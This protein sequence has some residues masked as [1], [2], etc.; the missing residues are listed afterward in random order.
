MASDEQIP[1]DVISMGSD[2]EDEHTPGEKRPLADVEGE[3]G[4]E[5]QPLHISKRPK[6]NRASLSSNASKAS[7]DGEIEES[8]SKSVGS[9]SGQSE[10]QST[11]KS[12]VPSDPPLFTTDTVTLK[13]PALS[14][15]K[16]GSWVERVSDW[17]GVLCTTNF[18]SLA[19]IK[20]TTV[21]SAFGQ[22]VD[23]YSGLKPPKKRT[24]KQTVRSME[25]SGKI[26]TILANA[27]PPEP[28]P[29]QEDGE[30]ED[31]EIADSPEYEPREPQPGEMS[32]QTNG[33]PEGA[34]SATNGEVA[35]VREPTAEQ[36]RYFPSAENAA[37]MCLL[38]GR[39]GHFSDSCANSKCKFC[40]EA[41]HW[42]FTCKAIQARCGKCR[43][44][45]HESSSCVEKLALTKDEGLA[46]AFC[47][48]E[49]H[50]EGECTEPWRSFHAEGETVMPVI[51][52]NAS[53]A[54][55]GSRNHFASDCSQ[56]GGRPFNPTWTLRNRDLF[57]D[58]NCGNESIEE[59][60]SLHLGGKPKT[61]RQETKIRGHHSRTMNVHYSESDDS[62]MDLIR[63]APRQPRQPLG[64][65]QMSTNIQMPTLGG[66]VVQPPLPPGPPPPLPPPPG[67]H[68]PPPG[69]SSYGRPHGGPPPSL[70]P[71]PPAARSKGRGPPPPPPRGGGDSRRGGH[72]RGRG[73]PPRG[74][75]GPPRGR[76]GRGGG[77]GG[78]RGRERR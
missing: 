66:H 28:A 77:G 16:E 27:Q 17:T 15:K 75:G 8:F 1:G 57:V 78:G 63:A 18:D 50:L 64:R 38:C 53:C 70:P 43:Q 40:G 11:A 10:S 39:R 26:A 59:A 62:D 13:L 74:R 61:G 31:G 44:L 58:P 22:Y 55:C 23:V 52:I 54:V 30:V 56:R 45:G 6:F 34:A 32:Q 29:A 72:S 35:P 65:I 21:V 19:D 69:T 41:G 36:R 48:M 14:Q 3:V 9:Q 4:E 24:A 60:S 49:H 42:A 73:G 33:H 25:E 20:P 67:R 2:T 68:P 47:G 76:G 37:D 71:K 46:C 12:F 5:D 7:E 51:A